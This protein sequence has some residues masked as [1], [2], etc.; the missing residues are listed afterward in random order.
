MEEEGAAMGGEGPEVAGPQ[1]RGH[2]GVQLSKPRA[3]PGA[4]LPAGGW[5]ERWPPRG[6]GGGAASPGD[7]RQP[8]G[9]GA[10]S[11][12]PFPSPSARGSAA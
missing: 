11:P 10:T 6:R 4:A 7:L 3:E 9:R 5:G 1:A 8:R 12:R 2:S